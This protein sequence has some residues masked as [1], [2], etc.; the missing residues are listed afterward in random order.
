MSLR[1][2]A[3]IGQLIEHETDREQVCKLIDAAARCVNDAREDSISMET[4][5]AAE[6]KA[7]MQFA[8]LASRKQTRLAWLIILVNQT[9]HLSNARITS[10]WP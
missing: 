3:T 1:N 10:E 6:Y 5:L 9:T 7:S 2:L 8:M 4:R